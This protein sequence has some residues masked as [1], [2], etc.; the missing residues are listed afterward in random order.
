MIMPTSVRFA[1]IGLALALSSCAGESAPP[2]GGTAEPDIATMSFAPALEIDVSTMTRSPRGVWI[3]DL[4]VG[5]GEPVGSG[6][7]VAIRYAG[8]LADGTQFDATRPIDP[9]F[10]FRIDAGDVIP[11]FDEAVTGMR[12]GGKRLAI[13]PPALGYRSRANGPI[14]ANSVLVFTIELVE[15]P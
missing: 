11:G 1:P 2:P 15:A 3:K 4:A 14:P 13:I 9:P 12:Q 7:L 5:A 8:H 10:E 6:S